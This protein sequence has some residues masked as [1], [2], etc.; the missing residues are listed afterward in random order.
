VEISER[1]E[2]VPVRAERPER[3]RAGRLAASGRASATF[4]AHLIAVARQE[5]QTRERR[6]LDPGEAAGCYNKVSRPSPLASGR[7]MSR[8][9]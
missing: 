7:A 8:A 5:P 6:R 2:L 1:R 3:R 9:M 4:L